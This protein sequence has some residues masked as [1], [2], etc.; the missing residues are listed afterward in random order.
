VQTRMLIASLKLLVVIL[1]FFCV[2]LPGFFSFGNVYRPK[3]PVLGTPRADGFKYD[4]VSLSTSDGESIRGWFLFGTKRSPLVVVC[5]GVGTNRE[6]LRGVS[7]FLCRAGFNVLAFDFRAHGESTGSK[8]TFGFR[9]ALDVQAAVQYA[10]IHYEQQFEGVGVYAISMGSAA[11]IIAARHMPQVKAFVLDSP[12]ARLADLVD[13]QFS[14]WPQPPRWLLVSLA[15]FYGWLFTGIGATEI[16]PVD[17][18]PNLGMRPVLVFHGDQDTLIPIAQGR[19]LFERIPGPK[20]FVET[21]GAAHVQS[22][23]VMGGAYEKKV[24]EFFRHHVGP[25]TNLAHSVAQP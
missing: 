12:F 7:R 17:Y 22:Y 20:E 8:T 10:T 18:A 13:E 3:R 21:Q 25:V 9:E 6:D 16:A 4:S 23:A 24:V 5:H 14:H 2:F 11:A 15:G 1:V 19:Q